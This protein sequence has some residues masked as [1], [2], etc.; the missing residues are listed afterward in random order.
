ML[1]NKN[2][3]PQAEMLA[4]RVKKR[5]K[6]LRKWAKRE[7]VEAFRLY[8][9]DIPEI[10]LV[11]DLYG[12]RH[13]CVISGALYKRPYQKDPAEEALWLEAMREALAGTV[14][15]NII[16][17]QRERQYGQAQYEKIAGRALIR[18]IR[19]G[20]YVFKV[21]LS[22]YLDTGLFL[23]RRALRALI[24]EQAR[25]RHVLNLFCYTAS[26][27]VYAAGGGAAST[28]SVDLSNTYLNWARENFALNG[29][30]AKQ[31]RLEEFFPRS[32]T[33]PAFAGSAAFAESAASAG[34]A[35]HRL[36]RADVNAF[37]ERA[38]QARYTWDSIILDPPAF[39]NSKMARGDFDLAKDYE[40]LLANCLA[41]LSPGG[42]LWFSASA[43]SFRANAAELEKK[44]AGRLSGLKVTDISEKVIDEDFRGKKTPKTFTINN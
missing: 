32:V 5:L 10:P 8:D 39:S 38:A 4:N 19:E 2:L 42:K 7:G 14:T 17:K 11:L 18:E 21:N 23:D 43:R 26:F 27:S 34:S 35:A 40:D 3:C 15:K 37:L 36:I 33:K 22:D 16:I 13:D 9:R 30:E 6:H 41:L 20:N 29:F 31:M 28:D 12:D 1:T 25:D 24:G 44:L